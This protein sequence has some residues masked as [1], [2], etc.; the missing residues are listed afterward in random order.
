MHNENRDNCVRAIIHGTT[1][2][3]NWREKIF[4]QYRDERNLW[5][6]KAL[7]KLAGDALSMTDHAWAK[8]EPYYAEG[9]EPFRN[10]VSDTARHVGFEHKSKSFPFFVNNLVAT[11]TAVN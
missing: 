4:Q 8:L 2:T 6:S 5:S 7:H 9:S 10:A 3:A 11:L 1:R